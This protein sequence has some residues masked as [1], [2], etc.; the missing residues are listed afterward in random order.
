MRVLFTVSDLDLGGAQKQLVELA[1]ELV[2][3]G[4]DVAVYTMNDVVPRAKDLQG[5]GVELIVD[6]KRSKLD[7]K[8]IG[9]LRRFVRSWKP[10][11]VHAFL[12][13]AE[14]YSRLACVA[15]GVPVLNSERSDN[16]TISGTQRMGHW[17]TKALVDGVVA[18]S[19]SGSRFAQKLYGYAPEQMHV[20]WNGMRIDEFERRGESAVG[21]KREFFGRDDVKVAVLIGAIKPAKD[22]PLALRTAAELFRKDPGWRVLFLGDSLAG[23]AGYKA[24]VHS[25][26]SA[27]KEEAMRLHAELGLGDRAKFAGNRKDLPAIVAQCDVL[28]VTSAWEG[29]PN[30]VLEAMVLGVPVVS[31]DYSDIRHILPRGEQVI[32]S[33]RPGEMA[34]AIVEAF[35]DRDEIAAEQKRW[36]RTHASI[37]TATENLERVY[38]QYLRP[39]LLARPA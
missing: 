30:S 1:R 29:F 4:H 11:I 10:D 7:G 8:V 16:Y 23:A 33:R 6:Q 19:R 28:F 27:Y 34:E 25:D 31:T 38:R 12:F 15:T 2:R 18:N 13:D 37:E 17:L 14:I 20:V 22:Y 35:I 3:R 21:Y 5:S 26:T 9:R 24:G 32:A 39:S 36:V